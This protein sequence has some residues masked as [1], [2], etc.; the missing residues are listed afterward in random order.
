MAEER[1][2][3]YLRDR[4]DED[5][6]RVSF[7]ELFFDLVFV[8]AVTQLAAYL[9]ENL[10]AEGIVRATVLFLAVWWIWITTTW[11]TN[12]LDPDRSL[13]RSVIFVLMG[14]GLMFSVSIPQ[15]FGD[16]GLVFAL[17]YVLIQVGRSAFLVW[18]LRHAGEHAQQATFVRNTVWFGIS[19]VLWIAGA[20]AET[21]LRIVIWAV[22][23][24][25]E[26]AVPWVG[27]WLPRL[28]RSSPGAWDVEGEHLTER[29]GLFII[30]SLGESI[31]VTGSRMEPLELNAVNLVAFAIAILG[32][33]V[34]WWVYFDTGARRGTKAFERSREPGRLA[35]F[36]YT[37]VH[38][39]I[40]AG[41]VV[42]A[43]SDK[44][45]LAHPEDRPDF[46]SAVVILGGPG[47]FL[48]GNF[49]FKNAISH[50][51]PLSHVIG[52]AL[53]LVPLPFLPSFSLIA[54]AAWT[55][56]A[57]IVVAYLERLFLRSREAARVGVN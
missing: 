5:S 25:I 1:P 55:V 46:A 17:A 12:R 43:V 8:F 9:A 38:L 2:R 3:G 45:L 48:L 10:T 37:Y 39:P 22:A 11:A 26:L 56:A 19:G 31:L 32:S 24:L 27:Y 50:R 30:L 15:A 44:L 54:L 42:V 16:R 23:L 35:R 41:V 49:L 57:M 34:M 51:W 33:L 53:L 7:V 14:V 36:A 47:L 40:V 21:D 20:L 28:G 4:E 13:V 18:A 29:C 6:A 52:L